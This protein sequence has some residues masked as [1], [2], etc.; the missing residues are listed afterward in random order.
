MNLKVQRTDDAVTTTAMIN[1]GWRQ[2][3]DVLTF[4]AYSDTMKA[5]VLEKIAAGWPYRVTITDEK[6]VDGEWFEPLAPEAEA[7]RL[8]MR[9]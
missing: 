6:A 5:R 2:E 7:I 9:T 4:H 1:S 8:P 3:G